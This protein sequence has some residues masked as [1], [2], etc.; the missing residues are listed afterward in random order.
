M[1]STYT[2][3]FEAAYRQLRTILMG[4]TILNYA[5]INIE[6]GSEI[7]GRNS[8][9]Y[10]VDLLAILL[11]EPVRTCINHVIRN[12]RLISVSVRQLQTSIWLRF[13]DSTIWQH[14]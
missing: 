13:M 11:H 10:Y 6:L 4:Q 5:S 7:F 14:W 12:V 2:Y 8:P 1:Y 9:T 3:S